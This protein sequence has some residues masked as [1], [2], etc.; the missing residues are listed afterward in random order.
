M[1]ETGA[2]SPES[3][4]PAPAL[5]TPWPAGVGA[6][7]PSDHAAVAATAAAAAARRAARPRVPAGPHWLP[8]AAL[9]AGLVGAVSVPGAPPGLGVAVTTVAVMAALVPAVRTRWSWWTL[10]AG[11]LT[12]LLAGA[13]VVRDAPWL[14]GLNLVAAFALGSIVLAGEGSFRGLLRGAASLLL[15]APMAP[16]H[17]GKPAL[18]MANP[19]SRRRLA[20]AA[21]AV[22]ASCGVLLLFGALFSSAD[23]AFGALAGRLVPTLSLGMFPSQAFVFAA[24]AGT[25]VAGALVAARVTPVGFSRGLHDVADLLLSPLDPAKMRARPSRI[26]WML[27]LAVLNMLFVCFVSVQFAVFFGGR[28]QLLTSPGLTAAEYARSGFFQLLVVCL[29]TLVVVAAAVRWVDASER[30]RLRLL[31]A[32]LCVLTG[33]VLLSAALRLRHYAEAFGYTRLRLVVSASMA[34]IAVVLLLL[35]VAGALWRADWLPRAVLVSAA[36]ALLSL[37]A[38]NADG[39][40]AGRNIDRAGKG[41]ALDT[42]YLSGLSADAVPQLLR[43]P[44]PDRTCVLET[45][46]HRLDQ[47]GG[48]WRGANVARSRAR[49]LLPPSVASCGTPRG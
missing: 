19:S 25:V 6:G 32:P 22:L 37:N 2:V 28:R 46:R 40:I 13:S 16:A 21:R 45:L 31:L 24:V 18:S 7:W 12:A 3:G 9:L 35:L 11:T 34:V 4:W 27:P 42:Y 26:E 44:E 39:F 14:I 17:V 8:L 23:G 33:V 48:G 29:L 5:P 38:L 1:S 47:A 41:A 10:C 30:V 15:A 49:S 20:P 43:L 36:V